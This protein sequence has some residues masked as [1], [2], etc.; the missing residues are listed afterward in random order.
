MRRATRSSY[1]R[2]LSSFVEGSFVSGITGAVGFTPLVRL[3]KLS[4]LTGCNI[5]AKCEWMNPGGSVKDRAAVFILRDA[6]EKGLLRPGGTVVEGTAGNTGI[7]LAMV[8]AAKGYRCKIFMPNTQSREKVAAL[9]AYGAE[10]EEVPAV[11]YS[12]PLNFNHRARDYAKGK[13]NCVWT[14]QFDNV[15]NRYGHFQ[16]TGPEIYSQTDGKIDA[17]TCATGTGGTLAGVAMY[18]KQKRPSIKIVLADPPGSVLYDAISTGV[19]P[20]TRSGG[21]ITEGIGQGRI[22]ANLEGAP[23]DEAIQITDEEAIRYTF[24]LLTDEGI[25][26]GAS[27]GLNVAAAVAVAK[28]MGPGHTVAT[29]LCDSGQRYQSRLFSKAWLESKNLL[30]SLDQEKHLRYLSE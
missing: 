23:I 1:N 30:D 9:R 16:S 7:G 12:N 26:V 13:D 18:M 19:V 4:D 22:T 17:F 27:S 5:L 8:C 3:H 2:S 21:S 24:D 10:I 25:F 6:E 20:S 15:A 11:A 28:K 14:D 29:I